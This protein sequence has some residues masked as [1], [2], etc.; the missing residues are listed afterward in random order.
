MEYSHTT[1]FTVDLVYTFTFV[2]AGDECDVDLAVHSRFSCLQ[3]L[4]YSVRMSAAVA[5]EFIN[6]SAA[7][8]ADA[9][10]QR[11]FVELRDL[12]EKKYVVH[13]YASRCLQ[14][15]HPCSR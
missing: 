6:R 8:H 15:I 7:G 9:S 13:A 12:Y 14:L 2:H 11:S 5:R 10:V 1:P 4:C 3:Q